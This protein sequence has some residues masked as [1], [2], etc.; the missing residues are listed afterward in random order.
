MAIMCT[1]T[2]TSDKD[3]KGRKLEPATYSAE[4]A[5]GQG[6]TS[7]HDWPA[8]SADAP[9]GDVELY[10]VQTEGSDYE[11]SLGDIPQRATREA[12]DEWLSGLGQVKRVQ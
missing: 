10:A 2:V 5:Q 12:M 9:R 3:A 1:I 4:R 6:V 11:T 8:L 7:V